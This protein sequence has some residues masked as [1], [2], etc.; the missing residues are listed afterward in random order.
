MANSPWKFGINPDIFQGD[1]EQKCVW[2]FSFWTPRILFQLMSL[3]EDLMREVQDLQAASKD[4]PSKMN[5]LLA[6]VSG[7][8]TVCQIFDEYY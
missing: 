4:L 1:I 8:I 7:L 2:V 5:E 6:D 3:V